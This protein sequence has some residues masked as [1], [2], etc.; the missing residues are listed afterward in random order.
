MKASEKIKE[1]P[2]AKQ[3]CYLHAVSGQMM[4]QSKENRWQRRE[5]GC[6]LP[7]VRWY[8]LLIHMLLFRRRLGP[9]EMMAMLSYAKMEQ[10]ASGMNE[11]MSR[12]YFAESGP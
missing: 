7:P 2:L 9:G 11:L 1:M 6:S 8:H 5:G 12:N 3:D 4:D 10:I